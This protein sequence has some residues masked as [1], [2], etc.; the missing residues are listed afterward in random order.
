MVF[1]NNDLPGIFAARAVSR[2]IRLHRLLPGET[3]AVVGDEV[4]A[5]ALARLIQSVGGKA[6]AVGAV[7]LKARGMSSVRGITVLL[8]GKE[9]RFD[10]D[11]VAVCAP[12]APSFE[13][14]RQAGVQ[15]NWQDRDKL[16]V[17]ASDA[18]GRTPQRSI[19]IAGELKGPMSAAA[20][21]ETGRRAALAMLGTAA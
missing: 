13:L 17:V 11:A 20:A 6:V 15:V 12:Q 14:A 2:M 10:V 5:T 19:F 16:F 21:A 8:Q 9:A 7:P 4:E 1:E 18:D 3:I